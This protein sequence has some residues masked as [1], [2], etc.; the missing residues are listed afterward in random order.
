VT[1]VQWQSV[2]DAAE[3]AFSVDLPAGWSHEVAMLR[4]GAEQRRV[5]RAV[6][7]TAP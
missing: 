1:S 3:G 4:I 5:V 6:S 7:R 2:T